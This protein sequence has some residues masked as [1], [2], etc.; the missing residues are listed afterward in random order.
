MPRA[1]RVSSACLPPSARSRVALSPS[2]RAFA[3]LTPSSS[4]RPSLPTPPSSA[5]P[6]SSRACSCCYRVLLRSRVSP[7]T[8]APCCCAASLTPQTRRARSPLP[9]QAP[10][11]TRD[12]EPLAS[13]VATLLARACVFACCYRAAA[14]WLRS[15]PT[16]S[17][18][19]RAHPDASPHSP[20]RP[21]TDQTVF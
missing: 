17:P 2:A 10:C 1:F 12:V 4:R 15:L 7:R 13:S 11:R 3:P 14:L 20:H 16:H 9:V 8:F 18:F 5:C 21:R 6:C 19:A